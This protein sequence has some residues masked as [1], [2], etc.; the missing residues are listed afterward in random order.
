MGLAFQGL[1]G[2]LAGAGNSAA[3]AMQMNMAAQLQ[4]ERDA[5]NAVREQNLAK[6]RGSIELSNAQTVHGMQPSTSYDPATGRQLTYDEA[7]QAD[8]AS[9]TGQKTAEQNATISPYT[10]NG[11]PATYSQVGAAGAANNT[12]TGLIQKYTAAGDAMDHAANNDPNMVGPQ[13]FPNTPG[14][15][16]GNLTPEE[17][18]QLDTAQSKG[19]LIK[20]TP[21]AM[22][23]MKLEN[24]KA[25]S[26]NKLESWKQVADIRAQAVMQSADTRLQAAIAVANIHATSKNSDEYRQAQIEVKKAE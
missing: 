23:E 6:L 2:A 26:E 20:Y 4:Q 24:Q 12:T 10:V 15:R 3:G 1:M 17:Q 25:L 5:A 11:L 9:V 22:L 18:A 16:S 21:E 8:P 19:G 13:V 7:A 14:A